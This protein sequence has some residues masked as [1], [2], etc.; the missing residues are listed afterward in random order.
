MNATNGAEFRRRLSA[1]GAACEDIIPLDIPPEQRARAIARVIAAVSALSTKSPKLM[2]CTAQS[3]AKSIAICA[4]L[5]LVPSLGRHSP[6]DLIPRKTEC[7]AQISAR[8]LSTLAQ[9]RGW[10]L[11]PELVYA[12]EP[13]EM[14]TVNGERRLL[15]EPNPDRAP[16]DWKTLEPLRGAYVVA[17]HPTQG[18]VWRYM[19]REDI[20][21]R[22]QQSQDYGYDIKD[23]RTPDHCKAG[24]WLKWPEEMILKTVIAYGL[25]RHMVPLEDSLSYALQMIDNERV[26]IDADAVETPARSG[27]A[28]FRRALPAPNVA[29]DA[30]AEEWR[31][32]AEGHT[33]E[34]EKAPAGHVDGSTIDRLESMLDAD[35]GPGDFAKMRA[36][37]GMPTARI[38]SE[39]SPEAQARYLDLLQAEADRLYPE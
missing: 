39:G 36:D 35:F 13:F 24:P 28:A 4:A 18:S 11:S 34:P 1:I 22:R 19:T 21:K 6:I 14:R 7:C 23:N 32:A 29:A 10:L 25:N 2:Q 16:L 33:P 27:A 12:G 31:R 8:G 5:D 26:V 37:A 20:L 30:E 9:R 38:W 17:T 15:H 3:L